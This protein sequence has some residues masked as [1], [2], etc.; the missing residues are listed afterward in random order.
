ME[1]SLQN[2]VDQTSLKWIFVGGKGG[3][4]KTTTSCCLGV[5][6]AQSRRN[7]LIVSTDP[8][9]NLSDAFGQK[10]SRTP[11]LVNGLS[12]LFCMEIDP[13][14]EVEEGSDITEAGKEGNMIGSLLKDFSGSIPGV[15]E[16][17]SFAELMKHVQR[18][19]F[20]VTVFD[21]APTGHTLRL[22]ALPGMLDKALDKIISLKDKFGGLFGAVQGMMGGAAG[23]APSEDQLSS[24]MSKLDEL[25]GVID[26]V[27]TRIHN[28]DETTFV[29]V[30][31]P[32]F[33]SLYET[34]RL[35]QE[36]SKFE[37]DTH[38][39]VVNQ[40]LFVDK[41]SK[42]DRC[43]ARRRMQGKYLDQ[44]AD[45]Y[46]EDFHVVTT[47]LLNEEVRGPA[48]LKAF[49]NFLT[50]PYDP[51]TPMPAELNGGSC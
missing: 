44:I 26:A 51:E 35:V 23:G 21:T 36:L 24:V 41:N 46:G 7:V 30:C 19:E 20:D 29:C 37:I 6:L 14:I 11:T 1:P 34:E 12:N 16:V 32:E 15:D 3:V 49:S 5:Q 33:L 47:P 38:N 27:Q 8:A 45:L 9:H 31:I 2:L 40:I 43:L 18:L 13:T 25:K 48:R 10:F 17:M 22:L 50:T 28:S 39:I 42:C 4:G